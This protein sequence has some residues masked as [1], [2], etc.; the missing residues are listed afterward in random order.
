MSKCEKLTQTAY[1]TSRPNCKLI[2][3]KCFN[4]EYGNLVT[5]PY[6][7]ALTALGAKVT[8]EKIKGDPVSYL[9][10][11]SQSDESHLKKGEKQDV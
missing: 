3:L 8:I 2:G 7:D 5:V 9:I 10:K 6:L 1:C 4:C 11:R